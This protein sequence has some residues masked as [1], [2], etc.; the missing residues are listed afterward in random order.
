MS[1]LETDEQEVCPT[2]GDEFGSTRGMKVHHSKTHGESLAGV[3]VECDWCESQYTDYKSKIDTS[4]NNFCSHECHNSWKSDNL[5]GENNSSWD[6]GKEELT[7]DECG[8]VFERYNR[9]SQ[10][11]E[12]NF[13]STECYGEWA[14]ENLV[15]EN[16]P[17]Y[18][19]GKL[20][21]ECNQ[22]GENHT[23]K[24]SEV[25]DEGRH[26][27]SQECMGIWR[28]NNVVGSNHPSYNGG[29]IEVE[30]HQCGD[31][32]ERE[33]NQIEASE[34]Q[35]CSP[36]CLYTWM[37]EYQCGENHPCW[38]GGYN[39]FYYGSGWNKS[40]RHRVRKRDDFECQECGI[41]QEES[42]EEMGRKLDVHHITPAREFDDPHERNAISN[43]TTLCQSCH[44]K[45]EVRD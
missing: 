14:S 28:S 11:T 21:V 45:V 9:D 25:R 35:F 22:C 4:E 16:N 27:C 39:D 18:E 20:S 31:K 36:T 34:H 1:T 12:H 10:S 37:S 32:I 23:R 8:D 15:G 17:S 26:F 42:I 6:G 29:K 38:D 19:G 30:C 3:E 2:C 24:V 44:R 13:C 41:T 40:K 43:L 5:V 33:P 7:C